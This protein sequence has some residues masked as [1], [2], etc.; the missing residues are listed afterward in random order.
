M[1]PSS[2]AISLILLL[3]A[4]PPLCTRFPIAAPEDCTRSAPATTA[5]F[6]PAEEAEAAREKEDAARFKDGGIGGR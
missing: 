5:R 6:A 1:L 2:P 3:R 4:A